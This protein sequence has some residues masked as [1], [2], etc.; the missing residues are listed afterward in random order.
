MVKHLENHILIK[1]T[2]L[3]ELNAKLENINSLISNYSV[4]NNENMPGNSI[5]EKDILKSLFNIINYKTNES[6][7]KVPLSVL[8]IQEADNVSNKISVSLV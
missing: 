3:L 2:E 8:F 6:H 5:C 4:N 1:E 7:K